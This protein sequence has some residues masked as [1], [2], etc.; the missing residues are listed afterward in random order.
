MHRRTP[1]FARVSPAHDETMERVYDLL[2]PVPVNTVSWV[3]PLGVASLEND[4]EP[5]D[6]SSRLPPD[7]TAENVVADTPLPHVSVPP[8]TPQLPLEVVIVKLLVVPEKWYVAS[9]CVDH[10]PPVRRPPVVLAWIV[11][12][13][14]RPPEPCSR[15]R[16]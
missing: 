2:W 7:D 1:V 14:G 5:E 8:E 16:Q 6:A 11:P 10:V 9:V 4:V 3:L 15:A 13:L 12:V